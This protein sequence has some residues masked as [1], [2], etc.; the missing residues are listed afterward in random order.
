MPTGPM[1]ME[2]WWCVLIEWETPGWLGMD[3]AE[4]EQRMGRPV[5]S[6]PLWLPMFGA[7]L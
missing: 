4:A 6:V 7:P 1:A 3:S 2:W 5:R